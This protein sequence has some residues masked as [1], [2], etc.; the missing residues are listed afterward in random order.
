MSIRG[1]LVRR[2]KPDETVVF[3]WIT[4]PARPVRDEGLK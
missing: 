4:W 2:R 1:G 3:S